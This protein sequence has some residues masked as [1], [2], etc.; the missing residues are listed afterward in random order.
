VKRSSK[1]PSTTCRAKEPLFLAVLRLPRRGWWVDHEALPAILA[2][3]LRVASPGANTLTTYGNDT[4]T[5]PRTALLLRVSLRVLRKASETGTGGQDILM[6][7]KIHAVERADHR[8][9]TASVAW[10]QQLLVCIF[11]IRTLFKPLFF[12]YIHLAV[13]DPVRR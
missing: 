3:R 10:W 4:A 8:S 6:F 12:F 9:F 1:F 5:I 2:P 13:S 7:K 11:V